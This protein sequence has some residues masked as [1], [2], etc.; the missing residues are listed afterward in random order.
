M[1]LNVDEVVRD[2][3]SK[4]ARERQESLCRPIDSDT[5][6]LERLPQEVLSRDCGPSGRE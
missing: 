6:Y 4:G 3:Y 1:S 2:R 5:R